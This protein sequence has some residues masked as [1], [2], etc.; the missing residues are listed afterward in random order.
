MTITVEGP[1]GVTIDFP[2]GTSP[3]IIDSVMRRAVSP[4]QPS[5][6][7]DALKSAGVGVAKGLIGIAGLPGLAQEGVGAGMEW[8]QRKGVLPPSPGTPQQQAQAMQDMPDLLPG[9]DTIQKAVEGVTGGFYKPQTRAG[10]YA[11]TTGEFATNAL[12]PGGMVRRA[13]QV[14]VPGVASERAGELTKGTGYEPIARVAAA[15]AGGV[16][17]TGAEAAIGRA[18]SGVP[19]AS[20]PASRVLVKNVP[21]GAEARAAELGPEAMLLDTAEPVVTVAKGIASRPGSAQQTIVDAVTAR[22][23]GANVRIR[24]ELDQTLGPAVSPARVE[25]YLEDQRLGLSPLYQ[26]MTGLNNPVDLRAV[27]DQLRMEIPQESGATQQAL[28]RIMDMVAPQPQG[29][30]A[31][32][33]RTVRTSPREVLNVRQALDDLHGTLGE[34]PKA[35]RTVAEYRRLVDEALADAVPDIKVLDETFANLSRSSEALRTGGRVLRHEGPE[36][37]RPE[38]LIAERA[39]MRAPQREAMRLG[40]RA[41]LDR[42]VGTT[43]NDVQALKRAVMTEGD[44][45]PVKLAE[46]FGGAETQR[47]MHAVDREAAFQDAYRKLTQNSQT[48]PR[49]HGAEAVPGPADLKGV[50]VLGAGLTGLQ[51]AY[52]AVTEALSNANVRAADEELARAFTT[53]G[54]ARDQLLRDIR[55]AQARR[56][57][58][59][60]PTRDMLIRFFNNLQAAG[61][62]SQ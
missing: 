2:D 60:T 5:T 59:S 7:L 12:L 51:K 18:R 41:D 27:Y 54:T 42:I 28:R 3:E 47:I 9:A 38:D 16:G 15:L 20:G 55:N 25:Q 22:N 14:A 61:N 34:T 31:N 39:T 13:A 26:Q 57:Q 56:Q 36:T 30:A 24:D 40:A 49:L 4:D 10:R 8:L 21:P 35:Q 44:W 23:R 17:A 33:P 46:I 58:Y 6:T 43:I 53:T 50:T 19:G 45:N 29:G 32:A 62:P 11:E 37:I 52:R 48:A 1:G